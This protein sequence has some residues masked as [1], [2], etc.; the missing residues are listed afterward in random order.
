MIK[1][2]S[3]SNQSP[4]MNMDTQPMISIRDLSWRVNDLSIL[5]DID[6][7]I[8]RDGFIGLIGPNGSGKTSLLRVLYRFLHPTSG[9]V[10]LNGKSIWRYSQREYSQFIGVVLQE[11]PRK[12]GLSI[13][14]V[15]ALGMI[16]KSGL[17]S[18]A[19]P[20]TSQIQKVL[21]QVG[22]TSF[23]RTNFDDLSGGEKQRCMI[24]RA[25]IQEPELLIFDEPTNH[26]DIHYQFDIL[27]LVR[28]IGKTAIAS[29]HDLNLA[30]TYCDSVIVLDK[31]RVAA[32]GKPEKIITPQLLNDVFQVKGVVDIHP[33]S[34]EPY[35]F[36]NYGNKK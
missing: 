30:M 12:I 17:F 11:S 36:V 1:T 10:N 26:L 19:A 25:L 15:V 16:P 29:I 28:Q 18:W 14:Q 8:H 7:D 35:I 3:C 23:A 5:K 2:K 34:K 20:T 31:G 33:I 13:E 24:A 27:N 9:D 6:L 21:E 32:Q 4:I 22:L